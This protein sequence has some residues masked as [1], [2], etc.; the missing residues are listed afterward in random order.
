M[1]KIKLISFFITLALLVGITAFGQNNTSK[2]GIRGIAVLELFTSEGCSS[3][4]PADELMGRIQK[5]YKGSNLFVLSY[6]VDYWDHQGWKDVFGDAAYTKRQ[7]EY[8]RFLG[9]EPIYTPQVIINGKVDYI[10]SDEAVVRGA[11]KKAL[12]RPAVR[13]LSLKATVVNNK[14]TVKYII[15]EVTKNSHLLLAVIQKSA[16]SDVK[17]GENAHRVLSHF[18]IVHQLHST[19]I[20]KE[21]TGSST[22]SLPKGFNTKDF[23]IVGFIQDMNSG[24]ILGANRA[25]F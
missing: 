1:K 13:D 16:K 23:E 19:A 14:I 8:A 4:P 24:T 20:K 12:S 10:A 25:I 22:M 11:L 6:H 9:K 2:E 7:Y 15:D 18:Q 17:R 21:T 3:C 5:E